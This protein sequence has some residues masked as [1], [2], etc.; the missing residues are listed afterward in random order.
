MRE[1]HF[2]Q[3]EHAALRGIAICYGV[4]EDGDL[5][6]QTR[7]ALRNE[8]RLARAILRSQQP[9]RRLLFWRR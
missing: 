4:P 8:R 6:R 1:I 2:T 7:D 5:H 3:A 9:W